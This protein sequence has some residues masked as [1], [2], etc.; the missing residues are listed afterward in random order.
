MVPTT[1]R[2]VLRTVGAGALTTLA[3]CSVFD[4][5]ADPD[6][7]R[8]GSIGIRNHHDEAHEVR[9]EVVADGERRYTG[10]TDIE[11]AEGN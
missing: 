6:P 3:G 1:R 8:I 4:S 2:A 10:R 7:L 5:P 11:A 9:V